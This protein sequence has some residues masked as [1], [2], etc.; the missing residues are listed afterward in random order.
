[1][2]TTSPL[3]FLAI[4]TLACAKPAPPS[5]PVAPPPPTAA[6]EGAWI[7]TAKAA[8]SAPEHLPELMGSYFDT[9]VLVAVATAPS[10]LALLLDSAD[11]DGAPMGCAVTTSLPL[12]ALAPGGDFTVAADAIPLVGED[13]IAFTLSQA[14]IHGTVSPDGLSL[15]RITGTV[16]SGAFVSM[17]GASDRSALCDMV[18]Q[19]I[20]CGPCP[21]GGDTCWALT[22]APALTAAAPFPARDAPDVCADPRCSDRPFCSDGPAPARLD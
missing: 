1:M 3:L 18:G 6:P 20:P 2:R 8:I 11:A 15:S 13:D 16:D 17:V 9:Q 14:R 4:L 21:D 22:M 12:G 7:L 19:K 10:G 5:L